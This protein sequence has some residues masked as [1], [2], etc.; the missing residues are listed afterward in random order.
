MAVIMIIIG[1][2]GISSHQGTGI[3]YGSAT[4]YL[5]WFC[6]YELTIGPIGYVIVGEI[7]S[8]RLRS[9]SIALSRNAY[10]MFGI[11]SFTVAPYILNRT[12]GNWKG[13]SGFLAGRLCLIC[14]LWAWFR[15]PESKDR[16]YKELDMMFAKK[17]KSWEFKKYEINHQ[18]DS[19]NKV[20]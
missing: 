9:K 11:I 16:T 19:R 4:V 2:M 5:L 8:T 18:H 15:L 1:F 17:L 3:G 10:N 6:G 7:S 20:A 14:A 13:R 12:G